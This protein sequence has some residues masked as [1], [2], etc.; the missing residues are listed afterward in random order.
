MNV[1]NNINK[2]NRKAIESRI[3]IERFD[4]TTKEVQIRKDQT[5]NRGV[6]LIKLWHVMGSKL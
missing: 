1:S 5:E 2:C 4:S 3:K 6:G